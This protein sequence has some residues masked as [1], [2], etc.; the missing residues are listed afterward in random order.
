MAEISKFVGEQIRY[1]RKL[2]GYT[3]KDFSNIIGRSISAVSKYENGTISIDINTLQLISEAL[4]INLE[5]L[6]PP[7]IS[8]AHADRGTHK[9]EL[10]PSNFFLQHD[11]YYMY[12]SFNS[13]ARD[14][15]KGITTSVIEIHRQDNG[16]DTMVM[17]SDCSE[18]RGNYRKSLYV[19]KGTVLYY[20]FVV[21]FF[22]D[23]LYHS[24]GLDYICA[25]VPF[26]HNSRTTG[27]YTGLSESMRNPAV[28]KVV[29]SGTP[30]DL[31]DELAN[32]LMISDKESIHDIKHR[33][34]LIIR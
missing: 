22:L 27:L 24:G 33:N 6:L 10:N 28:T 31:T 18:P 9:T 23:N 2:R 19:Y 14:E 12:F 5:Q 34:A 16:P 26:K 11:I 7:V 30:L 3:L 17:Y 32:E 29:I 1:F 25:K 8:P 20:D 4:E 13:N 21:Y 15:N